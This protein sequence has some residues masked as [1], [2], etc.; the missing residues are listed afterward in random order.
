[1]TPLYHITLDLKIDFRGVS[2]MTIDKKG[3]I[4]RRIAGFRWD[5]VSYSSKFSGDYLFGI[6]VHVSCIA[7]KAKIP[8]GFVK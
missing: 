7:S 8:T 2:T 5:S 1:M 4:C 3:T 6:S